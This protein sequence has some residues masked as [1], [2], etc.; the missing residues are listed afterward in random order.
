MHHLY[1]VHSNPTWWV[2]KKALVMPRSNTRVRVDLSTYRHR[3]RSSR[4]TDTQTHIP[5]GGHTPPFIRVIAD[6]S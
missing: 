1:N 4:H 5:K 2:G 6:A 3:H